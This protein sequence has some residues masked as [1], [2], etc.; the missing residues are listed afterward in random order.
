MS[1]KGRPS[2]LISLYGI[3]VLEKNAILTINDGYLTL[4]L[5]NG[6]IK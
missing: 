1:V 3:N 6:T 5:I 4:K 2:D